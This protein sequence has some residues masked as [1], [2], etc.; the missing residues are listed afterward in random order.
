MKKITFTLILSAILTCWCGGEIQAQ[1]FLKNLSNAI[2]KAAS[3][4]DKATDEILGTSSTTA[5][6]PSA[7]TD[8]ESSSGVSV[9]IEPF[10]TENTKKVYV[11]HTSGLDIVGNLS[12]GVMWAC[13][14]KSND[15][16]FNSDHWVLYDTLGNAT[17]LTWTNSRMGTGYG[18]QVPRFHKGVAPFSYYNADSGSRG[19]NLVRP[20]GVP[21]MS[22]ENVCP[23]SRFNN[24]GIAVGR[25]TRMPKGG[26]SMSHQI[27]SV[28]Y[29][30]TRGGDCFGKYQFRC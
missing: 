6:T 29:Y 9:A 11:N 26:Y 10:V 25:N 22:V 15:G 21:Y 17:G 30:D 16:R 7:G 27:Y 4:V 2:E 1:K 28:V 5:N 12:D 8:G 19:V 3:A 20:D 14:G 13:D 24:I 18:T 23:C